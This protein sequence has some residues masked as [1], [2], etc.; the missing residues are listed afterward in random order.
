MLPG[1][2]LRLHRAIIYCI[3]L[4]FLHIINTWQY[5]TLFPFQMTLML[6]RTLR[7]SSR[8]SFTDSCPRISRF[9]SSTT[10][11][12]QHFSRNVDE[13]SIASAQHRPR[14]SGPSLGCLISE[15]SA[16]T[17][18]MLLQGMR[19]EGN[20][21]AEEQRTFARK[22]AIGLLGLPIVL[23]SVLVGTNL[24]IKHTSED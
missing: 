11:S 6:H 8:D 13:S 1:L 2:T 5:R 10:K 18:Q 23:G 9:A 20:T 22:V 15:L 24:V 3:L 7:I 21:M 4:F 12:R 19:I 16:T 14:L 17:P